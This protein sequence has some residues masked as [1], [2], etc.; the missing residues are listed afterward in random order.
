M[1]RQTISRLAHAHH[2]V[3]APLSDG[4]VAELLERALAPEEE[5]RALDLGCGQGVWLLRALAARPRWRAVGVDLDT[6]ALT[7]ARESAEALGV[8][9]RI[10]LHHL[11]AREFTDREPFELVLNVGATH[12]FGGLL[13]TLD[14][15]RR[16]LAPGGRVLV[17]EAFWEREPSSAALAG[18]G[19]AR[20]EYANLATTVD[21]VVADGWTPV[22]GRVSSQQEW[23]DYEFSWTGSLAQWALDHPEHPDAADARAAADLH[24]AEWLHGYRGTLGF[25]VLVLRRD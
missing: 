8:Q 16:H 25:V 19:A 23:D 4:S 24:R 3:A 21:R 7:W 10:G 22:Y 5:G 18:L 13:P 6:A 14:A 11:D 2:P 20:E 12:A 15:A 17:G 9:R 1:D